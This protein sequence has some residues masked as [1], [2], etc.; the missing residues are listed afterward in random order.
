MSKHSTLD[1]IL[2]ESRQKSKRRRMI[3]DIALLR[4]AEAPSVVSPQ[5]IMDVGAAANIVGSD[6][7]KSSRRN[8][9]FTSESSLHFSF[10]TEHCHTLISLD[11]IRASLVTDQFS[12]TTS[13]ICYTTTIKNF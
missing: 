7:Y 5:V 12:Y 2:P 8:K 6:L 13:Y 11:N 4:L 10:L 3:D 1:D 9:T